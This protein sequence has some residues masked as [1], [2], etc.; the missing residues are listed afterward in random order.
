MQK[1]RAPCMLLSS[2]MQKEQWTYEYTLLYC[3]FVQYGWGGW[4]A[5]LLH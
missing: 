4:A 2:H 3:I 1:I 5:I